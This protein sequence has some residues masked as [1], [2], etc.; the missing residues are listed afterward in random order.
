MSNQTQVQDEK[1][2]ADGFS[3]KRRDNAPDFVVGSISVKVD[4]ATTFL[5]DNAKNGW[6]NIDIKTAKSGK[7]Y[8][9]LDTWEPTKKEVVTETKDDLPF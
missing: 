5:K 6:V 1:I 2:F 9:E 3:F 4:E 7:P 8:M